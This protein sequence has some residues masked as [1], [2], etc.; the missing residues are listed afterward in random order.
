MPVRS[1]TL[2]VSG[3]C[4]VVEYAGTE[5]TPVEYK[6]GKPKV[7]S[8]D[9]VQLCAQAMCIEEMTGAAISE[10]AIFYGK[11]R[12]RHAVLLTPDLRK[13]VRFLAARMHQLA[14]ERKTPA[15]VFGRWC[16]LCSLV[17]VC[18]PQL[19]CA[20]GSSGREYMEREIKRALRQALE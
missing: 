4:D 19:T 6:R 18:L 11:V 12:R 17:D 13:R 1:L 16:R 5:I 2:G 9:E 7:D 15:A 3:V 10:G 20:G 8:C 14:A